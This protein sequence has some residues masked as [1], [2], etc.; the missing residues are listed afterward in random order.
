MI[1]F[2]IGKIVFVYLALLPVSGSNSEL[3]LSYA[4]VGWWNILYVFLVGPLNIRDTSGL[5][6]ALYATLIT[7]TIL[8][9]PHC[10]IQVN[11]TKGVLMIM[12]LPNQHSNFSKN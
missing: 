2:L 9:L 7:V 10:L 3:H 5:L 11:V 8:C 4:K 1:N 6:S 12:N